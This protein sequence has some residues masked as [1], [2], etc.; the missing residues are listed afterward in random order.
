[1]QQSIKEGTDKDKKTKDI[2]ATYSTVVMQN[3]NG[4]M[5]IVKN[6]TI[7]AAPTKAKVKDTI[8]QSDSAIDTETTEQINKFLTTFF[9]LYPKGTTNELKYYV[10][11]GTKPIN[12][13]YRFV[14]LVNPT[15]HKQ[16]DNI[17]VDVTVKYIDTDTDMTQLSQYTL[18][19]GKSRNNWIINS[20]F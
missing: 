14:E 16:G 10:K 12:K 7:A 18:N 3:A 15:F 2:T 20:D 5:V 8:Q 9:T 19:L 17:K 6:P 4:D 11:D 13:N 1:M